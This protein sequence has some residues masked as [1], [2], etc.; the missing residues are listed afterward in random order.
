MLS[1]VL[2]SRTAVQASIQIARAFVRLRR[3]IAAHKDLS[4]RFD[5]LERQVAVHG[6]QI[7]NLFDAIKSLIDSPP[8]EPKAIGFRP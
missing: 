5:K 1:A 2:R 6:R 8:G 7:D 4:R 3:L